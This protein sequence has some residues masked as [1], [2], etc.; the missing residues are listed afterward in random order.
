MKNLCIL[1]FGLIAITS[2]TAQDWQ[3]QNPLPQGNSLNC[4][5]FVDENIGYA[6]GDMGTII[7]TSDGGTTWITQNSG[8]LYHLF[9][10]FFTD[11]STGYAVG[12]AGTIIK[13]TDGGLSWTCQNSGTIYNL[14]SIFFVDSD[15][16]YAGRLKT[17]D[18]GNT[19]EEMA[20][21]IG[22]IYSIFFIPSI[23][24]DTG[25]IVGTGANGQGG[26]ISK[27][28]DSGE[29]WTAQNSGT[30]HPLR[31]VFFLNSQTGYSVGDSGTIVKTVDGG[32]NWI[33]LN[34]GTFHRLN[35]VTFINND[36]GFAAGAEG[37][38]IQTTDGGTTWAIQSSDASINLASVHFPNSNTGYIVGASGKI[39]KTENSGSSWA[40]I[41]LGTT[42]PLSSIFFT[43][44][45]TGY[46]VGSKG[47][48]LKTSNGGQLWSNLNSGTMHDLT[49]V[50]FTDPN[51]G[52][53][54]GDSGVILQTNN[55]G[56]S[57]LAQAS[58]TYKRLNSIHFPDATTGYAVG[59][60]GTILKTNDAGITW[61]DISTYTTFTLFSVFFTDPDTGYAAGRSP[62]G[63]GGCGIVLK[64]LN[65]GTDWTI[66]RET[67]SNFG[68]HY[69][70][71][72]FT[73]TNTGWII[74]AFT[75]GA[76]ESNPRFEKT[77]NGGT[78]WTGVA[79]G[80]WPYSIYF[81]SP[82]TGYVVGSDIGIIANEFNILKT[83][84]SGEE[85]TH[86][87]SG[88]NNTLNAVFF[89]NGETGYVVGEGGTIQKTDN[90]GGF[91]VGVNSIISSATTFLKIYPNPSS[92][93][94]TV[95][96]FAK[97]HLSIL[98]LNGQVVIT[99]QITDPKTQFDISNLP[100]GIFLVKLVGANGVQVGKILKK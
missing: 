96:T 89:T 47:T 90:G 32:S 72:Y 10:V 30:T 26:K 23:G 44:T 74:G 78:D 65:G 71:V 57:W 53:V 50:F 54:A 60:G 58:G 42:D 52:Y 4:V 82:D 95:E 63:W 98:N 59:Q 39:L 83:T 94:I 75:N 76:G 27:T 20:N 38:I 8:T 62:Y 12:E 55:A 11:A 77:I 2:T 85:W 14:F 31:S 15:T 40:N 3:W 13:T 97:G 61:F 18:G 79:C 66:C 56:T 70:Q 21:D 80:I 17:V 6:V 9:S 1:F 93:I 88:T 28:T 81:S 73:D 86:H 29:Y 34:S 5:R 64:T 33:T 24:S 99:H 48:I 51:K 84:N 100:S 35:S 19:W 22:W 37:I 36:I 16:G 43:E 91:P 46:V 49:S 25:Y 68:A 41:S 87:Y 7:K 67:C 92:N 69:G 45:N